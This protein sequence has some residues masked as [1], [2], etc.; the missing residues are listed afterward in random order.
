MIYESK[1]QNIFQKVAYK[2][3]KENPYTTYKYI[4]IYKL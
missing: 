1:L 2:D 4:T 3:A